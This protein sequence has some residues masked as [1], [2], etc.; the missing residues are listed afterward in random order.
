MSDKWWTIIDFKT[1]STRK[2][3]HGSL[4][5][6]EHNAGTKLE[7]LVW[8][9]IKMWKM[10]L[11]GLKSSWQPD[12]SK[13]QLLQFRHPWWSLWEYVCYSDIS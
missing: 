5:Y 7:K 4:N 11:S 10:Y 13:N 1:G 12:S 3:R 6:F 2:S 8:L 9:L